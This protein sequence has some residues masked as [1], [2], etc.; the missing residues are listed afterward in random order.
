MCEESTGPWYGIHT[1]WMWQV[2]RVEFRQRKIHVWNQIQSNLFLDWSTEMCPRTKESSPIWY[3]GS[4]RAD[5]SEK[6]DTRFWKENESSLIQ[7]Y[8]AYESRGSGSW[9][10][11]LRIFIHGF[12]QYLFKSSD[13]D[14]FEELVDRTKELINSF[15]VIGIAEI[16]RMQPEE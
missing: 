3:Y 10:F 6:E 15:G 13:F 8:Q 14:C 12:G 1:I 2:F 16:E 4:A 9:K 7:S 11:N 5:D